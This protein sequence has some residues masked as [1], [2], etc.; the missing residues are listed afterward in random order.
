VPDKATLTFRV[1]ERPFITS[2]RIEGNEELKKEDLE[3]ALKV[4]PRTIYDPEKVRHGIADARRL[5]EEKGYLDVSIDPILEPGKE[6]NEVELVYKIVEGEKIRVAD[7]VFEG[8][9][10]FSA[11]DLRGVMQTKEKGLFSFIT[12]SGTLNRDALKTDVERL[13]AYYYDDGY[14]NV[15]IDEP[16]SS[17]RAMRS[18]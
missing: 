11:G 7:I 18:R 2:V 15:K 10:H 14:V 9:E 17:A 8:N 16:R 12:G 5:F 6:P 13:T 3:S 4:R 1:K